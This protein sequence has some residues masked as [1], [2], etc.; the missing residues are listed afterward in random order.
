M[1]LPG[2]GAGAPLRRLS[3]AAS[4]DRDGTQPIPA[5]SDIDAWRGPLT[6]PPMTPE[7]LLMETTAQRQQRYLP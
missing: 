7:A 5:C 4:A 6:L 1:V 3:W 2:I